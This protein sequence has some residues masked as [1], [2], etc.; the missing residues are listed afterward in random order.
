ML[1]QKLLF[2]I[3]LALGLSSAGLASDKYIGVES[4][5]SST[6][7]GAKSARDNRNV[8]QNEYTTWFRFGQHSR[9]L[10][11]LHSDAA[12]TITQT[13][14]QPLPWENKSCL[15]CHS[16]NV[17]AEQRSASYSEEDGITCE[18]CHGPAEKWASTHHR[19][20]TLG[21]K[22][23]SI[24]E[25]AQE[26]ASCLSCHSP[27]VEKP[28]TH[29]MF[30]A[31]HPPLSF[32]LV[33]FSKLQPTHV[34]YDEDYVERK[35]KTS[36]LARWFA[37]QVA[38]SMNYLERLEKHIPSSV[39]LV[40]D[41]ALFTCHSCHQSAIRP[42]AIASEKPGALQPDTSSIQMIAIAAEASDWS[43]A[44]E[45]RDA[46]STWTASSSHSKPAFLAATA[47]LWSWIKAISSDRYFNV[48]LNSREMKT[49]IR[50]VLKQQVAAGKFKYWTNAEQ[51]YYLIN[52][53][54]PLAPQQGLLN[55]LSSPD[56]FDATQFQAEFSELE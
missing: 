27:T 55:S 19:G 51:A 43:H 39:A 38:S 34:A 47:D 12:T 30:S 40:P 28:M 5:A 6:C 9:S 45:L 44:D 23:A 17:A 53:S 41:G 49:A 37:G 31:G 4:C 3:T 14:G 48:F 33:T 13:L 18:A 2:T 10:Q 1:L 29:Q 54:H 22:P 25:P 24:W 16:N 8:L 50:E 35:G 20:K 32:E 52:I 21:P 26:A 7:H 36:D 42:Q 11:T 56:N 15:G 46:I